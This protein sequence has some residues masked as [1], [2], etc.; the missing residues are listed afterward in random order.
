MTQRDDAQRVRAAAG[1]ARAAG[2]ALRAMPLARR[3]K[4]IA[5]AA[6]GLSRGAGGEAKALRQ[7]LQA[8]T[9]LSAP[10][11]EWGLS[12]TL[13]TLDEA[14]LRALAQDVVD[15]G[16]D[17]GSGGAPPS[18]VAVVLS[19]NVF[20]A[21]LRAMLLP[22]LVGAPV[23]CKASS[24]D[25]VLARAF[26]DALRQADAELG[27]A[28]QVLSFGRDD[29]EALRALTAHAGVVSAYGDD[30]SLDAI[31]E[32]LPGGARLL[33]HGHG[34]GAVYV[35]WQALVSTREALSVARRVALDVAAY[36]Q[37]GCLSPHFVLVQ[38]GGAVDAESFAEALSKHALVEVEAILPRGALSQAALAE[39]MQWRGVAAARGTLLEGRAHG[40]SCEDRQA[41][42]PSPGYR[43]IGVYACHDAAHFA[44][45]LSDCG[46]QLK[47]VAVAGGPEERE[48]MTEALREEELSPRVCR[49][50]SIQTPP[51]DAPADGHHPLWGL[52]H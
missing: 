45:K 41:L 1:E 3:C 7:A 15:G 27:A 39:Q 19:G 29:G 33:R 47:A 28:A 34:L 4:A 31:A 51:L 14:G 9:G 22:L 43:N 10:M 18:L 12:S 32:A 42:R 20:T 26:A 52:T 16:G 38:S 24:D 6:R 49:V 30:A 11:I 37:R 23:V 35:P 17:G 40:V 44:E 5:E 25:D 36:D 48:A 2:E 50:G 46:E 21:P 13:A 8:S